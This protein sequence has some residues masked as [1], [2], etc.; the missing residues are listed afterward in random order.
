[1]FKLLRYFSITSLIAFVIVA[2]LS[3]WFYRQIVLNNLK[4]IAE[5]KNVAL[6][7]TFSNSLWPRFA[8]FV[9]SASALGPEEL[10]NHPQIAELR[11]AV[12]NQMV[13]LSVVKVKVYDLNGKTVFSTETRQIGEDKSANAGFLAARSGQVAS[14][15]THRDTFSAFEGEIEDR[16]VFSSY[17]PIRRGGAAGP[18]EGVF[19]VY[20]DVTPLVNRLNRA[21]QN[22]I[23]GVTVT[24][25][26]LYLA[27]FFIV[28]HADKVL[29]S[30][31]NDLREG[32]EALKQSEERFRQVTTSISDHIY[33]TRVGADGK[34]T[35][36]YLSPNV[37]TLTG[38]PLQKFIS[39]WSFWPSFVIH[40][41]DRARAARQ[42]QQLAA[43]HNSE[44]EYRLVRADGE[45]IWVRDSGRVEEDNADQSRVIFGIVSDITER[46][47]VEEALRESEQRL[48]AVVN[49]APLTLFALDKQGNFVLSEGRALELLGLQP[50]ELAGQSIF[51]IYK[52]SNH[53]IIKSVNAA[54]NGQV[55]AIT[56][57]ID[58]HVFDVWYE[59]FR[60]HNNNVVGVVGVALDVTGRKKAEE[61]LRLRDRAI[62][63]STNGITIVD[64]AQPDLPVIFVNPAFEQITGYNAQEVLG[65]NCRFLQNNDRSQSALAEIRQAIK[66]GQSCT[67]VLRNYRKDGVLFWNELNISP[68]F[69]NQGNVTHF[70]GIQVDITA[71]KQAEQELARAHQKEME[72]SRLK[73][74]LLANVSHDIRTPLNAILGYAEMLQEGVYGP[75][76]QTQQRA[77]SEIIDS[78]G[79][80]LYFVNN[81]LDQARIESGQVRLRSTPFNPGELIDSVSS[82]VGALVRSKQL[83]FSTQV[84]ANLPQ[85]LMG[86]PYW[87]RQILV[88]LV[89]N[90]IKFT[91]QGLVQVQLYLYDDKRWAM[92]VSD[93]GVGIAAKDQKYIFNAFTQVDGTTTRHHSGSGLGLSIVNQLTTL[94]RGEIVL[95]SKPGF[96]STFTVILPLI[97]VA[98]NM[99]QPV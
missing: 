46:K 45:I 19:E 86:D 83:K 79:Q 95:Q 44:T 17:I 14:E 24:L 94:M 22:I 28:R 75:I 29:H 34:H 5:N 37:E 88:N 61:G 48:R 64:A 25:T 67:A 20:D 96:G 2:V 89:S 21:Q 84:N 53:Q 82:V 92:S 35:N 38:Y 60:D 47:Q 72:A 32:R 58:G 69:D 59:P 56:T 74:Q 39:D 1:M 81:L 42:A 70:V 73:S 6:T 51:N 27:L 18:I 62:A 54:L 12:L 97:P 50:E 78:T 11:Q 65:R 16:D 85:T 71:R 30:Q 43:G 91:E 63:A 77:T 41:E 99:E 36:L 52:D 76:T 26:G 15:L 66:K 40:P 93:T 57:Q 31:Y 7:Q 33:M 80:L 90:A 10:Q 3:G 9:E 68:I 55:S 49:S 13:G 87:L 23:A 4:E 98:E 8:P